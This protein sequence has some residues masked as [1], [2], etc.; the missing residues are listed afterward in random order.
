MNE[1]M[2]AVAQIPKPNDVISPVFH[3]VVI[4]TS[5]IDK[6]VDWYCLVLGAQVMARV[7][8]RGRRLVFITFD[9]EHH[10]IAFLDVPNQWDGD[11]SHSGLQHLGY[12]YNSLSDLVKTYERV[13]AEG[14]VPARTTN[15]GFTTSNYYFDPDENEMEMFADNMASTEKINEWLGRGLFDQDAYGQEFDF[16]DL[17]DKFNAGAPEDDLLKPWG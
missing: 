11:R 16:Q 4:R 5:Q 15:H 3:H 7:S 9:N 10:R 6:M 1:A 13:K 14:I 12:K 8:A 17:A 2:T